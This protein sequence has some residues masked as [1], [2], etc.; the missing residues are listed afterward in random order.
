RAA[1]LPEVTGSAGATFTDNPAQTAVL[2]GGGA[3]EIYS[4]SVGISSFELDLFGRVRNLSRAAQ[5][6]YFA[7]EEGERAARISLIAEIA[8]AWLALASDQE[9]LQLAQQS[10]Q[11]WDETRKLTRAQFD[12]GSTSELESRQADAQYQSARNDLAVLQ[13][14]VLQDRNALDVLVGAPIADELLP[15]GLPTEGASLPMVP[16]QLP[17]DLLLARPDVI[18]AERLMLAQDANLGAARA[19]MFPSI[20]LTGSGG[21][22]SLA[23]S[24]LFSKGSYFYQG[25]PTLNLP[26]FDFGRRKAGVAVAKAQREAAMATY[27]KAIQTAFREVADAL[28]QRSTIDERVEAQTARADSA[29]VAADLA[30]ARYKQGASSFLQALDARRTD[31]AARQQ[32]VQTGLD[33]ELNRI[34]LYRTLGGGLR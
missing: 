25:G 24:D 33:R 13:S 7:S 6:Q 4:A 14:R 5:E 26:I 31:Y 21:S 19:A 17:S 32:R 20:S 3:L 11:T 9:Q 10:L 30:E 16:S 34:A 8:N 29:R 2:G 15:A 12:V 28:A 27:E 22:Q 1:R 23:L 18:Q